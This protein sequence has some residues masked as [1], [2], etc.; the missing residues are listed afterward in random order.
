MEVLARRRVALIVSL[1][2][3]LLTG[4][5]APPG[6]VLPQSHGSSVPFNRAR[7]WMLPEAKGKHLLYITNYTAVEVYTYPGDNL[8][9]ELTGFSLPY[10]DCTDRQGNVYITD[11]D[12]GT[13]TEYAHAA[14][15]P[16]R[17]LSVPG[18]APFACAIDAS[19]GDLAVTSEGNNSGYGADLAVYRKA[20]GKP[21]VYTDPNI[22]NYQY[23]TYDDAGNLFLDGT[24]PHGYDLPILAELPHGG[25]SIVT[26]KVDYKPEWIAGVQ[27]DG[28]YLAYG[29]GV[30]PYI[31]Q[32][33]IDGSGGTRVGST[34]LSSAYW[35]TQ[36]IVDGKKAIVVNI[37]FEDRYIYRW[38]VFVFDYPGGGADTLDVLES[39]S[40]IASVALSR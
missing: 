37:H 35:A 23:C 24:Y 25:S 26:V 38:N 9:G 21:A 1:G 40:T 19:T 5:G 28:K 13:V 34:E 12:A 30:E 31:F 39:G 29:Q 16:I 14:T 17:T 15:Q 20:K 2:S 8:V 3:A 32:Y 7:S 27:W 4:C 10:G 33:A 11:L 22:T 36:F 6:G 18:N